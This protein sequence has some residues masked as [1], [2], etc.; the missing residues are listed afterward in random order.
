MNI[1][2]VENPR[3]LVWEVTWLASSPQSIWTETR[4]EPRQCGPN[5]G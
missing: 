5:P 4:T 2:V 3:R 1:L